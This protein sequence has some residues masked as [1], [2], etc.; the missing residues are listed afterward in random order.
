M[1][2]F[3]C[4]QY[5]E[6]LYENLI[7]VMTTKAR[8]FDQEM[9]QS[10]TNPRHSEEEISQNTAKLGVFVDED[11]DQPDNSYLKLE[12]LRVV[13]RSPDLLNNVKIAQGQLRLII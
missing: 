3:K 5:I 11:C 6:T 7:G 9:S 1:A 4:I 12:E 13:K 8:E 2:I 10:Q